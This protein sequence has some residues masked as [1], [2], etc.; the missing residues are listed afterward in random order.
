MKKTI[1]LILSMLFL[2]PA[3]AREK[4]RVYL[5]LGSDTSIWDGLSTTMYNDRYFKSALYTDPSEHAYAV[6]DSSFRSKLTDSYGTPMKMTWW[7]MAGN[8]FD[9]SKNCNIPIRTNI[10]LYLM[11][12]YHRKALD[13]WDDQLSLH[14]H[15]YYWSD[16]QND[17][18]YKW[19]QAPQR[20]DVH[21]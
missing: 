13:R 4:P 15:T 11:K 17:G 16:P 3:F 7:M 9:M 20:V 18:I 6:M 2:F 1:A 19:E 21:G 10:T 12:K 8:V 14:Y 5:V